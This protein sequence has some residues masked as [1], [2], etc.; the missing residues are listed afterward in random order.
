MDIALSTN[1]P[2]TLV[3]L[4]AADIAQYVGEGNIDIG[5]TGKNACTMQHHSARSTRV[6]HRMIDT[7]GDD[8]PYISNQMLLLLIRSGYHC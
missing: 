3:F 8:I 2:L 7:L 1:L 6:V 4:P 5:I